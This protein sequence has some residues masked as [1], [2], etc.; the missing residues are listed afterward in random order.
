MVDA[1]PND[2]NG[3]ATKKADNMI[4]NV[5]ITFYLF[6]NLTVSGR[7]NSSKLSLLGKIL[8]GDANKTI[9]RIPN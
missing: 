2:F 5:Q 3:K 4:Q 7:S 9:T 6:V 1:S 8:K